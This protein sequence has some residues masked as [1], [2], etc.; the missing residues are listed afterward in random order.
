MNVRTVIEV[1]SGS[2]SVEA[3]I[4]NRAIDV[5]VVNGPPVRISCAFLLRDAKVT[6]RNRGEADFRFGGAGTAR[7]RYP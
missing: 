4:D 2:A 3:R 7:D 5:Y 1:A 6:R